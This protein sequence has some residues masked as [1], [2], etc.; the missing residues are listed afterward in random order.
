MLQHSHRAACKQPTDQ[1]Q[2]AHMAPV[3]M[4]MSSTASTGSNYRHASWYMPCASLY[5]TNNR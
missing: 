1:L 4:A 2:G 3:R 5:S